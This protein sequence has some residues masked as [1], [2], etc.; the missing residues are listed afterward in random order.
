MGFHPSL[1]CAGTVFLK[2]VDH[3]TNVSVNPKFFA[4]FLID[5]H[6]WLCNTA[7]TIYHHCIKK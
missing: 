2:V 6:A 4:H 7:I 1:L 3:H 5:N